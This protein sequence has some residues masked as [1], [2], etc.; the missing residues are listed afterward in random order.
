MTAP[1]ET[2]APRDRAVIVILLIATFVVILNETIMNVA[3]PVLMKDLH[4]SAGNAQWLSTAFMLTMAVVIPITGFLLQRLATRTVFLLAMGLF[5]AGTLLAALAPGFVPLLLARVVQASGT[6]IMLPLLMTTVL[7]VV[8]ERTRGAVMGNISIVISVAPAIGP[9]ISGLILQ[10]LSWRFMFLFVL[11]IALAA[12]AYGAR[13]LGNVGERKDAPLDL[14]SIPL[15]A[16]GFGG[17][18]YALNQASGPG[19]FGSLNVLWPL[20]VAV[21]S[22]ILFVLRQ[23]MLI[24]R[25]APLLDLRAFRLPQ[26]TLGV[27]LMVIAM[28]ALFGGAILL[29]LYLQG[30]RGLNT[31][32]TG[33]LLLPGGLVMGLLSPLVGRWYDRVGPR[34][35][36]LPGT[37]LMA[38]VLFGLGHLT[39]GTPVWALLALH[40]TLSVG[41]ALLFTPVFTSSLGPLPP[42][43]YSHGSA[44]LSTLQQVAGAAGMAL[45]VTLYAARSAALAHGGAA[46]LLA[47]QG[48]IQLAFTVSA[49][50]AVVAIPL[51][52]GLRSTPQGTHGG[53]GHGTAETPTPQPGD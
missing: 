53:A 49:W 11:P 9:T 3:I 44:I 42:Q 50:I 14:V 13:M 23:Q 33:L 40:V 27:G 8:P 48:G 2:L 29:P 20:G 15:S 10:A 21:V 30:V 17:F 19:G 4:V 25:D 52:L 24:R 31:L 5:S 35:L 45:L 47:Q 41:L 38:G 51:S 12:L 46:P 28:M 36:T 6:A 16:L 1:P 22:L 7:T 34:P 43:L 37:V 32:Q 26:F 18:V 39:T